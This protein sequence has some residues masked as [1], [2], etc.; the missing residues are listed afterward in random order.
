[1]YNG[2]VGLTKIG[3]DSPFDK[4]SKI[5]KQQT[6]EKCLGYITCVENF[7]LPSILTEI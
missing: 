5:G 7:F 1:M 4:I 2:L 6:K 3:V